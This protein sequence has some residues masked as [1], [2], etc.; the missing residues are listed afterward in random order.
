[1]IKKMVDVV[2]AGPKRNL[3]IAAKNNPMLINLF[4]FLFSCS[5]QP[6]TC[7]SRAVKQNS[8]LKERLRLLN[9]AL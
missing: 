5:S 3:L 4:S 8:E 9:K 2:D 7:T 6:R 1:M